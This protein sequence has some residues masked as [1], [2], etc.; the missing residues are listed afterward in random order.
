MYIVASEFVQFNT[1]T[2]GG[3]FILTM[4]YSLWHRQFIIRNLKTRLFKNI[5]TNIITIFLVVCIYAISNFLISKN[6]VKFDFTREK[7]HSLS[8]Q[9]LKTIKN[10]KTEKLKLTLFSKRKDWPRFLNLLDMYAAVNSNIEIQAID[11]DKDPA[12]VKLNKVTENGTLIIKYKNQTFRS[13]VKDELSVTKLFMTILKPAELV[14]YVLKGHNE[15]SVDETGPGGLSFLKDKII[16]S[17]Y[18]VKTLEIGQS[19]PKD[20]AALLIMNP[21]ISFLESEIELIKKYLAGGGKLLL[22][23]APEFSQ[24]RLTHLGSLLNSI[25][26]E[27]KNAIVLDRLSPSLGG[28]ASVPIVNKYPENHQ[29]TKGFL[30]R[31]LFP[32]SGFYNV[33]KN[34]S[35][36]WDS[37]A[38]STPFPATWGETNFKE[39]QS[40]KAKFDNA[41]FKGPLN[42]AL[43]GKNEK[44]RVVL[45][46]S[47]TFI[48]NQFQGQTN[49]YNLFLNSLAWLVDE[50]TLLSL[51][52]PKLEG[53]L[54]YVSDIHFTFIFYFAILLF[55]FIFFVI[56]IITYKK[57]MSR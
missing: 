12:L 8:D 42:I 43:A 54:V 9:S 26:I 34:S 20:V 15:M 28:Q 1:V 44:S 17:N 7:I 38:K 30:G 48:S 35:Y 57:K 4:I 40:G 2:F 53:N 11:V 47:A 3:A 36:T 55:P 25:G 39:V 32:V 24:I 5:L 51:N 52:R 31:T 14:L 18:T 45:Y 22:T 23:M 29:I 27:F 21:K 13:V 19:L 41:D 37:F 10:L 46:S 16:N 33:N 56:A 49:N 50:K 6:D